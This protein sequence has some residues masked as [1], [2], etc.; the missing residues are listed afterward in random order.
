MFKR[1]FDSENK[2]RGG[3][4]GGRKRGREGWEE[5]V[6]GKEEEGEEEIYL[7]SINFMSWLN[8]C[9]K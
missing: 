1:A 8:D 5:G 6:K 9:I 3:E 2:G 4:G 7:K